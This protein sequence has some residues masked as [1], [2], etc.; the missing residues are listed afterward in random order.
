ME[1]PTKHNQKILLTFTS[2]QCLQR[3]DDVFIT[4]YCLIQSEHWGWLNVISQ[5][6]IILRSVSI[7]ASSSPIFAGLFTVS[8]KIIQKIL[9]IKK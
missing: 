9:K 8:I 6:S 5:I 4:T 2:T 1:Q 3:N 7:L